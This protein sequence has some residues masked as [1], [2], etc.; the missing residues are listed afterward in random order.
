MSRIHEALRK[1]AEERSAQASSRV[2]SELVELSSTEFA[3]TLLPEV[4]P[5]DGS[6]MGAGAAILPPL[7]QFL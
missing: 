4:K 7:D 2:S 5:S 3:T 1:A 6:L